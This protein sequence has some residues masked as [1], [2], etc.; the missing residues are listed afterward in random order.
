MFAF[1]TNGAALESPEPAGYH[2]AKEMNP[3]G[4]QMPLPC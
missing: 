3:E 2:A 1:D 4:V